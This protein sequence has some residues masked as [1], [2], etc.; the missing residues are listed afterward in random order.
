MSW[1]QRQPTNGPR[2]FTAGARRAFAVL[3]LALVLGCQGSSVPSVERG[4]GGSGERK[5]DTTS[6]VKQRQGSRMD[7]GPTWEDLLG[8]APRTFDEHDPVEPPPSE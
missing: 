6:P 2:W 3:A 5:P 7:D 4:C 1:T 8:E